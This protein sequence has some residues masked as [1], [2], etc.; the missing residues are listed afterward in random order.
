MQEL[1]SV[2]II[3]VY[4][5]S[6]VPVHSWEKTTSWSISPWDSQESPLPGGRCL[7]CKQQLVCSCFAPPSKIYFNLILTN[8]KRIFSSSYTII[9]ALASAQGSEKKKKKKKPNRE[10][11]ERSCQ[12]LYMF[13][14]TQQK[15]ELKAKI[16]PCSHQP[17]C[18][19]FLL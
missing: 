11:S 1:D 13:L 16:K 8:C 3:R 10:K 9:K 7:H 2:R 14:T 6:I 4:C 15:A 12:C 17:N 19:K 5:L 18:M